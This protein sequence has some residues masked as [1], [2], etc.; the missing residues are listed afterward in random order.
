MKN[1]AYI[2]QFSLLVFLSNSLLAQVPGC[3]SGGDQNT[4]GTNQWNVYRYSG[5]NSFTSYQNYYVDATNFNRNGSSQ[6]PSC[7]PTTAFTLRLKN[8][9]TSQPAGF[10]RIVAG[11][12]DG[13]RFNVSSSAITTSNANISSITWTGSWADQGYTTSTSTFYWSGGDM[14]LIMEYYQNGGGYQAS[15]NIC[16]I[17]SGDKSFGTYPT[18]K[19]NFFNANNNFSDASY[20]GNNTSSAPATGSPHVGIL[21][22]WF[23]SA[24]PSLLSASPAVGN[25]NL[26]CPATNFSARYRTNKTYTNGIYAFRTANGNNTNAND[27]GAGLT[28][29]AG[30]NV[31]GVSY[32][33]NLS[34]VTCNSQ[35]QVA[36]PVALNGTYSL[37]YD[38]VQGG[39]DARAALNECQMDAGGTAGSLGDATTAG[40]SAWN[41]YYYNYNSGYD[42]STK[43]YRGTNQLGSSTTTSASFNGAS[44]VSWPSGTAPT[45]TGQTCS[46]TLNSDFSLKALLTRSFNKGIY[47]FQTGA[48]DYS[49]IRING[50]SWLNTQS[51]CCQSNTTTQPMNGNTALEYWMYDS[52][53]DGT[54]LVNINCVTAVAGTLTSNQGCN[55]TGN[56][57]LSW[58]GG[59]GYYTLESSTDGTTYST[60]SGVSETNTVAAATGSWSVNPSVST[61]YRVRVESCNGSPIYSNIILVQR[62]GTNTGNLVVSSNIS[63][64]GTYNIAG[65]FTVNSGVTITMVQGCPLVVNAANITM[66][67]TINGQGKGYLGST[68]AG[69]GGQNWG[70][71]NTQNCGGGTGGGAGAGPG[72]GSAGGSG[73]TGA[74][75]GRGGSCSSGY[76]S[77]SGPNGYNDGG[78]GGAGGAGGSYGGAG[79]AGGDGAR[80]GW[81]SAPDWGC[82]TAACAGNAGGTGGSAA[83]TYGTSNGSD[84]DMG[85]G[86]GA[87]GGGGGGVTAGTAGTSGGN[88]G[89][90]VSLIACNSLTVG[91]TINVNG[92]AGTNGGGRGGDENDASNDLTPDAAGWYTCGTFVVDNCWSNRALMG[93]QGG[94]AAG[95]SGG[96][97][98]LQAFGPVTVSGTLS[99]IGGNG[100]AATGY[101]SSANANYTGSPKSWGSNNGYN[102][103]TLS[104]YGYYNAQNGAAGGGGR[105]KIFYNTCQNN[106]INT[107]TAAVAAG[108]PGSGSNNNTGNNGNTGTL[109]LVTHPSQTALTAGTITTS[110]YAYCIG[111]ASQPTDINAN[112]STGGAYNSGL[113][114][115]ASLPA[116]S[117]QW[118]GAYNA[119]ACPAG[120]TGGGSAAASG[121]SALS[122]ATSQNL[123]AAQ[124]SAF[125]AAQ[126]SN[127]T[128]FYCFQRRTQSVNCYAWTTVASVQVYPLPTITLGSNP[129]VCFSSSTQNAT[130]TYS[131]TA[132]GANQYYIDFDNTAN[133]AGLADVATSASPATLPASPIS[134]PVAANVAAATYNGTLYVKNSTTGCVSNGYAITLTINPKPTIT[135]TTT[136]AAVCF[137]A[138]AQTATLPYSATTNGANQYSYTFTPTTT[139]IPD[140][141]NTAFST[142]PLNIS[143][144]AGAAAA[145]YNGS[146]T[147]RNATTGCVSNA[148]AISVVVNPLPAIS[149]GTMPA[150][151]YSSGSQTAQVPYS[152]ATNLTASGNT[153]S[154]SF[155]SGI[156]AASNLSMSNSTSGTLDI[157]VNAALAAGTY[158]GTLTVKN[159]NGCVSAAYAITVTIDATSVGGTVTANQT[160]CTGNAP[161]TLTLGGNNGTVSK[162]MSATDAAF[163]SPTSIT[164]T[165]TSLNPG[166]LTASTYFR[167]VVKNGSCLSANSAAALI[168]VKSAALNCALAASGNSGVSLQEECAEG[169]WSYFVDPNNTTQYLFA[170]KKNGNSFTPVVT[171]HVKS[172]NPLAYDSA[173]NLGT[174]KAIFTMGRYWDVNYSGTLNTPVE[175]RFFYDPADTI[176]LRTAAARWAAA[177]PTSIP[178][179]T[180]KTG[181]VEWFKYSN[182]AFAPGSYTGAAMPANTKYSLANG[183]AQYGSLNGVSYVQY[184]GI[185]SFSGGTGGIQVFPVPS[186]SD[187][188]ALPVKMLYLH[189]NAKDNQYIHLEWATATEIDNAGFDVERSEDGRNFEKIGFVNGA[190]N[191]NHKLVYTFDD[192]HTAANTIYYYRLRQVDIDAHFTYTEIV[193]AELL[194][195]KGTLITELRPNPA[196]DQVFVYIHSNYNHHTDIVVTNV[197]GEEVLRVGTDL[198]IGYNGLSLKTAD[199][200]AGTYQV[201]IPEEGKMI[202][203][204]LVIAH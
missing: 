28:I 14:Y 76:C 199:L 194:S 162:W 43:Y 95:G 150:V 38:V 64:F 112:A 193:S 187:P 20:V 154:Y 23:N 186:G 191:S 155:S 147:V 26:T 117:Y 158:N 149:T 57:T 105:I 77:G 42:F 151:C 37:I 61:F 1:I 110:N 163:T 134:I 104:L 178:N 119:T 130:L 53:G 180:T 56:H 140:V 185:P 176:A 173:E 7:V 65:D 2:F 47:T 5:T 68:S 165:T 52:G 159:G 100:A 189:A 111:A 188:V 40:T 135:L 145:T 34:C 144:T 123:T 201:S 124:I 21:D 16:Q 113:S 94:G 9:L 202:T 10:Y 181:S 51:A 153:Y 27:D 109:A 195:V 103:I 143:I 170:I 79:G 89:G 169:G 98:L 148:T 128:G 139:A 15:F 99:A 174:N 82:N 114:C 126:G 85:S 24:A 101:P 97:I 19:S 172:A 203:K 58:T 196:A 18:W 3:V 164:N 90:A 74:R 8:K 36:D 96:G 131:A 48:D 91:G 39:G 141:S 183:T 11:G 125:I 136:S 83:A 156:T 171:L 63:M 25:C 33:S 132:N 179:Y 168:T 69:T 4:Y 137:N 177:H 60:A 81:F 88:G 115:A 72:G 161:I 116:Y 102:G 197:L 198:E 59:T 175:I 129:V 80:G 73:G 62:T 17:G 146:L 157:T 46:T 84:I 127:N 44:N 35:V 190:G 12:D 106:S 49:I 160:I 138:S 152:G 86:G 120:Q 122:G 118:Y 67:G 93:G 108:S 54:A 22:Q 167:A 166:T 31:D 182:A 75:Q 204:R 133:A 70:A 184:T 29:N 71:T 6:F 30:A 107:T 200:P 92:T 142:S 50:G 66:N 32:I 121:Y 13:Y 78:G 192:K 45:R 55:G 87:G 41:V